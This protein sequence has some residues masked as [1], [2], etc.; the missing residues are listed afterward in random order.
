MP[1]PVD[2]SNAGAVYSRTLPYRPKRRGYLVIRSRLIGTA[3]AAIL[4]AGLP[5]GTVAQDA[6]P[7]SPEGVDWA[8]TAYYDEAG[9]ELVAV[10]FEVEPTLRLQDG[11]ASGSGG[12]NEF[13][14]S[15]Q[16][17]GSS[18]RFGE[19]MTV[20]LAL[21]GDP[22]QPT[23]DAYLAALAD[24]DGWTI[25]AGVLE[26]SDGF[27]DVILTF[28]VPHIMWTTTQMTELMI[29]LEELRTGMAD[30]QVEA[31]TLRADMEGLNVSRLRERIKVL[32]ADNKK[33]K[34][35][36]QTLERAPL[37]DPTP[38]PTG[39]TSFSAAEK[40]LLGGIPPRIAK[41]CSPLRSSLPKGTRAAVTCTPNTSAV[42]GLDYFLM[43]GEDAA[44]SYGSVMNTF[45]VPKALASD[46]TCAQG[47]KSQRRWLARGWQAD[48]CYRTQGHA[49]VRFVDNATRCRKL[50]V[51]SRTLQSPAFYIALQGNDNNV[52]GVYGWAT[53]NLGVGLRSVDVDHASDPIQAGR[54]AIL[55]RLI[56]RGVE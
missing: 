31:E 43:E 17:D 7:S 12:C 6:V 23:E 25:D 55:P 42:S 56:R 22:A 27:G 13:S 11:A 4:A 30:A 37:T 53:R 10:P 46:Q 54:L 48:G 15:Y 35:Q 18:L 5:A 38:K 44:A 20:T 50:K 26:L 33:L 40:V 32:E 21:C 16:I 34:S 49:E 39:P 19:E 3:L 41:T 29:T 28:E 36:V 51:G 52:A 24:V 1:A 9:A 2:R 8:L 45:N 47:V 14:G